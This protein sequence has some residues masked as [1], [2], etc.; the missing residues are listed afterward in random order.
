V[1]RFKGCAEEEKPFLIQ[2]HRG[3]QLEFAAAHQSTTV[4]DWELVEIS[5]ESNVNYL[6]SSSR[7]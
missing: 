5:Y 3:V 4:D 6:G 2:W 1:S 7:K